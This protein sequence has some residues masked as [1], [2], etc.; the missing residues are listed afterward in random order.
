MVRTIRLDDARVSKLLSSLDA[1]T[2]TFAPRRHDPRYPYRVKGLVVHIQQHGSSEPV[3]FVV[4][5]RD[6]S[7][8]GLAFLHGGFVHIGSRCLVQL[9]T[10]H[11]SVVDMT[12]TVVRCQY[13]E[14][15][16]HEVGIVFD[17]EVNPS[18]FCTAAIRTRI[19]LVDDD[20][21]ILRLSRISLEQLNAEVVTAANGKAAIE[22]AG[23]GTF[24]LILLDIE[25][26][27]MDGFQVVA[28]LRKAGYAGTIVATTALTGP[29]DRRKCLDAGFDH[30]IA[31]PY[32]RD[33]LDKLLNAVREEPLFSSLEED[34]PLV[35]A[36]NGFVA[37]LPARIRRIES[38]AASGASAEMLVQLRSL[39][40]QA[41]AC[42]FEPISKLAAELE[43]ALLLGKEVG[44]LRDSVTRL[45]KLCAQA[46]PTSRHAAGESA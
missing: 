46:R 38:A 35:D 12:A 5:A 39:K 34:G 24:D 13:V 42:G 4:T 15:G 29:D 37:D 10:V 43:S 21:T 17:R 23:A 30:Y 7:A 14:A 31:K 19:L 36:I 20:D 8:S 6:I 1:N 44:D 18:T 22:A 32:R 28:E 2:S 33:D 45:R 40:S 25:M 41:G 11:G 3:P 9:L 27:E 16:V 26:P